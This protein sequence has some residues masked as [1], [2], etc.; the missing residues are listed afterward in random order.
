MNLVD[1]VH[2]LKTFFEEI[3][4]TRLRCCHLD[5]GSNGQRSGRSPLSD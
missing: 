4:R 2:L 5:T 1:V 3:A